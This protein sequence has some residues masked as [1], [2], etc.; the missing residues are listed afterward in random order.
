M[1]GTAR[2]P[3]LAFF[4]RSIINRPFRS[5]LL[6]PNSGFRLHAAASL[7]QGTTPL[8]VCLVSLSA[9]SASASI[10]LVARLRA[11][12]RAGGFCAWFQGGLV[13]GC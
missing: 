10:K 9:R 6:A 5:T 1:E 11:G 4:P 12:V 13:A 2:D 3:K 8:F 7:L